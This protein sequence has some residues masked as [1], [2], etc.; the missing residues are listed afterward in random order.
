MN[1]LIGPLENI[2]SRTISNIQTLAS[3]D[4]LKKKLQRIVVLFEFR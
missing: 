3:E 1:H 2:W 4:A